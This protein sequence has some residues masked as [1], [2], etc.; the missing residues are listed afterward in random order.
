MSPGHKEHF[1]ALPSPAERPFPASS[2]FQA[3]KIL[4][5]MWDADTYRSCMNKSKEDFYAI[6][7]GKHL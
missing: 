3:G 1:P 4:P 6:F 5:S 7:L 2:L